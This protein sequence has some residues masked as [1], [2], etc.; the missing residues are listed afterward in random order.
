MMSFQ[1]FAILVTASIVFVSSIGL[2]LWIRD[3]RLLKTVTKSNRGTKTERD[4]VLS[5]LKYGIPA[6]CIFHDLYV[7]KG[8]G[9]FS[10]IDLV[11]V[12]KVGLVVFEVKDFSGWIYGKANELQWTKVLAYGKVKHRFQ[13][14][15]MQN[16]G[17]I[18][19]LKKRIGHSDMP[20]YSIVVFYGNCVLKDIKYI[21][22]GTFLANA[23]RLR[24]VL[25]VVM[26]EKEP[27]PHAD[28]TEMIRILREAVTNGES[29]ETQT[30]HI[31]N[32]RKMFGKNRIFDHVETKPSRT[33]RRRYSFGTMVLWVSVALLAIFWFF[34]PATRDSVGTVQQAT[35]PTQWT[36]TE[37]AE[38]F[39]RPDM[40][41][42]IIGHLQSETSF[43]G[44]YE[45]THF[46]RVNLFDT[47]GKAVVGYIN[48][49]QLKK[50]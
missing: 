33:S 29:P 16:N 25:K 1:T 27:V 30:V 11:V 7:K 20:Y 2:L 37:Y 36:T 4:L 15:I 9:Q 18:E 28:K 19:A 48:T 5:L 24:D 42:S 12:A 14:P 44:L 47:K 35:T 6:D 21:P 8:N 26:N 38:V 31:E 32:V 43:K 39:A 23:E 13:N 46:V 45:T 40:Q 17:H 22:P 34:K 49:E 3:K 10:Q 41:S 50:K